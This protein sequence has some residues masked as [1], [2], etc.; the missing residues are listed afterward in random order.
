MPCLPRKTKQNSKESRSVECIL[1][2][3]AVIV[4]VSYFIPQFV[5][6]KKN[7]DHG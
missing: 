1:K 7:S 5:T 4:H 6:N 2:Y 3:F